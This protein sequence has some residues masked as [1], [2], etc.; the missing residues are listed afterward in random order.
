M[1]GVEVS[2]STVDEAVEHALRELGLARDQVEIE[3]VSEDSDEAVVIVT[4]L[5]GEDDLDDGD[6]DGQDEEEDEDEADEDAGDE[7][8]AH[9]VEDA[10]DDGKRP[11]AVQR[12]PRPAPAGEVEDPAEFAAQMLDRLLE[13]MSVRAD[14]S[15]R[16]AETPGDGLGM[17]NAV[18]DIEGEDLGLLIGRRGETLQSLQYLLNLMVAQQI[19]RQEFFT[20]DV[21]GYRRRREDQL[22]SL[23]R[24]M[25]DQVKRSGRPT[26]LDPMPANERRIIHLALSEN[27]YV[28]TESTGEGDDRRIA[29][30]P[31]R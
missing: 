21:E 26:T 27:R 13:L 15:I 5:D 6:G 4:P 16:D 30:S 12:E 29:I 17:A 20:V 9:G 24:R 19:G 7:D 25:A 3:I 28:K 18:L 22:N 1:D 8:V 14:V 31:K 2:A 10:G 23:A 11:A